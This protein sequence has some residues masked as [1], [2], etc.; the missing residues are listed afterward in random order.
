MRHFCA[1]T[2]ETQTKNRG[3]IEFHASREGIYQHELTSARAS[4]RWMRG[5]G[6]DEADILMRMGQEKFALLRGY[7]VLQCGRTMGLPVKADAGK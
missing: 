3:T 6:Y 4:L 2:T 1:W 5:V 7:R